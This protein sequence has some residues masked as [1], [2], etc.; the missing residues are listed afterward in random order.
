MVSRPP[1]G[2]THAWMAIPTVEGP[3]PAIDF[4][5]KPPETEFERPQMD[6]VALRRATEATKG[7]FYT[8]QT[9]K[10]LLQDLP[11]GRQV[12]V[13]SLPPKPLWNKWPVLL[14][15]LVLLSGEWILRKLG[16]MV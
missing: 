3:A 6:A 8:F 16:G 11:A 10:R 13:E 9:A 15:F 14:L 1:V 5:V 7:R 12:P 2:K 4:V